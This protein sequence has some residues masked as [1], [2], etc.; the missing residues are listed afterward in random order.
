MNDNSS[1]HAG[2]SGAGPGPG[3][4][5]WRSG[6]LFDAHGT[7]IAD[8]RAEVLRV[9]DQRLLLERSQNR[10]SFSLRGTAVDGTVF[11]LSQSGFTVANLQGDCQGRRY[12]LLRHKPWRKERVI[13]E[14]GTGERVVRVRPRLDNSLQIE[15]GPEVA[16]SQLLDVVFLTY[17]CTLVDLPG[18]NLR[19]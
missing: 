8:V 17:G 12:E 15:G 1:E 14:T 4:W 18:R 19:I 6:E 11:G 13:T 16:R 7:M 2:R 5:V 9:N 3:A 10:M